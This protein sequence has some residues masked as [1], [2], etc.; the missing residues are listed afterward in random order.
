VPT[1]RSANAAA[2]AGQ[3]DQGRDYCYDGPIPRTVFS[4]VMAALP[5]DLRSFAF[6]DFRAGN[7]RTALLASALKFEVIYGYAFSPQAYEDLE[8]NIA[9]Y[10]R[11]LMACRD[12]RVVRG[13]IDGISIPEQPCVLFFPDSIRERHLNTILNHIAS[14]FRLNPRPLYVVFDNAPKGLELEHKDIFERV[15]L[16]LASVL[17]LALLSPARMRIFRSVLVREAAG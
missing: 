6:V 1:G 15:P 12:L 13:D 4:W 3:P 7:G 5:Q 14:S 17:K 9:Q 16:P 8:L 2:M 11:S 10:P